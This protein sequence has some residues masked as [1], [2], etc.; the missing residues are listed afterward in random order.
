MVPEKPI[1]PVDADTVSNAMAMHARGDWSDAI[2]YMIDENDKLIRNG[3]RPPDE[4]FDTLAYL[5]YDAPAC[6]RQV[7]ADCIAA[8][9]DA[10]DWGVEMQ[11]DRRV[12]SAGVAFFTGKAMERQHRFDEMKRYF[13]FAIQI[14][15]N[16]MAANL[17]L[18]VY[19]MINSENE[20]NS[21]DEDFDVK[22]MIRRGLAA[23]PATP[24]DWFQLARYKMMIVDK[25]GAAAA[26]DQAVDDCSAQ[27]KS[28]AVGQFEMFKQI[29]KA[30]PS[31]TG[32]YR[33][34]EL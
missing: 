5:Y 13:K 33:Y 21:Q 16:Y 9:N 20:I 19:K 30:V 4:Y 31:N 14:N 24:E 15:E 27:F 34:E 26:L 25:E 7:S 11:K 18:A 32:K 1:A 6:A 8:M 28:N 17:A 3:I 2:Y 12:H 23:T 10:I 29:T 22:E